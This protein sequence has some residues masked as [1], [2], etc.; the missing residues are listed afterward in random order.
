M[1][2]IRT[3][4]VAAI[5]SATA[6]SPAAR[7]QPA[8]DLLRAVREATERLDYATAEE[9]AR[10]A[11]ADYS[12]FSPGELAELHTTLGVLLAARAEDADARTQFAAALSIDPSRTLD[13]VLVPPRTVALFESVRETAVIGAPAAPAVL[14]YVVLPDPRAGAALRS[15]VLPGWGQ[16]HRGD[17]GRGIAFAAVVGTAA[18]GAIG[19]HLAYGAARDRY[20]L[21]A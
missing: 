15:A 10:E 11:L 16:I 6:L 19:A 12:A 20:D 9:R 2:R 4:L 14:R 13:P 3:A 8:Q 7:A 18:G 21:A 17:R 5:L 1:N